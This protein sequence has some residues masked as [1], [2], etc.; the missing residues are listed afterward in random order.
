[1]EPTAHAWSDESTVTD[2]SLLSGDIDVFA[3]INGV[4]DRAARRG[5]DVHVSHNLVPYYGREFADH[6]RDDVSIFVTRSGPV[7]PD[8][9]L[10]GD[11][12]GIRS[13][14]VPSAP[15]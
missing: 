11:S 15:P 14:Q 6:G 12:M 1:M 5:W 2:R 7:P 8:G 4:A 13:Y 9:V 3:P 10:L